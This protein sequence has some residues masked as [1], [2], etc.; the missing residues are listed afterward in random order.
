MLWKIL[1][2][3]LLYGSNVTVNQKSSNIFGKMMTDKEILNI[4]WGFFWSYIFF[5]DECHKLNLEKKK[6]KTKKKG[7]EGR[8][9]EGKNEKR[10]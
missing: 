1:P 5:P 3:I 7:K 6:K 4:F 8:P 9:G 10:D 2:S